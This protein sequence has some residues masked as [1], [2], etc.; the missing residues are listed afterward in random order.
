MYIYIYDIYVLFHS[1]CH[2]ACSFVSWLSLSLLSLSLLFS[3]AV[4]LVSLPA[5]L[6][7]LG[8]LHVVALVA[9]LGNCKTLTVNI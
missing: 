5:L 8:W 1:L 4:V 6:V 2:F 7:W 3:L 9:P